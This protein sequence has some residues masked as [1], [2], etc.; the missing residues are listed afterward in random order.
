MITD[1]ALGISQIR[2]R[3]GVRSFGRVVVEAA[4]LVLVA[5]GVPALAVRLLAGASLPALL[6]GAAA[7]G[8]C[9]VGAVVA[10]RRVL[11]VERAVAAL[12][13]GRLR[14]A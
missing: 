13:P 12:V 1:A 6:A 2:R 5:F 9:L 10:R 8:I 3:L 7:G 4:V 11:G 14:R